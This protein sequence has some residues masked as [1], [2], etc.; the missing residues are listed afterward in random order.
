MNKIKKKELLV[1]VEEPQFFRHAA[2][3]K[4]REVTVCVMTFAI[5]VAILTDGYIS[6]DMV[7]A[8]E[9]VAKGFPEANLHFNY[10]SQAPAF[11]FSV[12]GK[13]ECRG[14]DNHDQRIG[15]A[16]AEAK[17]LVKAYTV[18]S[19]VVAGIKSKV[20]NTL[21]RLNDISDFIASNQYREQN[22]IESEHYMRILQRDNSSN[23]GQN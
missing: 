16:V 21:A 9:K 20:R 11:I 4:H 13:T 6:K 22:Y 3:E 18:A 14:N 15:D 8:V 12:K 23:I 17:A 19:R 2:N 7:K 5:P 1:H 10:N